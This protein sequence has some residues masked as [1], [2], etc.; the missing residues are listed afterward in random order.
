MAN[1]CDKPGC[2]RE[3]VW[4]DPG[5]GVEPGHCCPR[6]DDAHA[7]CA[8]LAESRL[9]RGMVD[10][11]EAMTRAALEPLGCGFPFDHHAAEWAA[12]QI[13]GLKQ[14]LSE[15][16]SLLSNTSATAQQV[17]A[18]IER[19]VRESV[20]ASVKDMWGASPMQFRAAILGE[21]GKQ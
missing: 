15:A 19:E 2:G 10:A 18:E 4:A 5:F 7:L 17:K 1:Y 14:E 20:W 11:Q 9:C 3:M 21:K 8:K 13:E 16:Q 12:D 6:D